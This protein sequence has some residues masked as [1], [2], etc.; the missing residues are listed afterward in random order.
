M[1]NYN[2]EVIEILTPPA[3]KSYISLHRK[4]QNINS[5]I[6]FINELNKNIID[7]LP[8]IN[9][10]DKV[11]LLNS[12]YEVSEY[13]YCCMEYIC[14]IIRDAC[15]ISIS[16]ELKDG[17]NSLLSDIDRFREG[18]KQSKVYSDIVI[19]NYIS[20][21]EEWYNIIHDIRTEETHY[22]SGEILVDE[23]NTRWLIYKNTL[24]SGRGN[25]KEILISIDQLSKIH[26]S[27][28]MFLNQLD[29]V[30][31]YIVSLTK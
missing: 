8:T 17:F 23:N 15:R 28:S 2:E 5:K 30:I 22:G 26:F 19:R 16:E 13:F 18:K 3:K 20:Q 6:S 7:G 31:K 14:Q 24:R 27:Y 9:E 10:S 1:N 11:E 21:A 4:S 12:I 25:T 29:I